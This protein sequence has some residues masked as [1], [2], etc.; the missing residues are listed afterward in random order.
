MNRQRN[1]R[2]EKDLTML[3]ENYSRLNKE[4][5]ELKHDYKKEEEDFSVL[6]KEFTENSTK[7]ELRRRRRTT[8]SLIKNV[9]S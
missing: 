2:S 6:D 8:L 4:F 7:T 3:Q 9:P 1:I 5:T